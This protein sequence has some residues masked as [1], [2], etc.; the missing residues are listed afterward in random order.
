MLTM[1]KGQF[2]PVLIKNMEF[3]VN[4]VL[5]QQQRFLGHFLAV[6]VDQLNTVVVVR[7]MASRNHDTTV[8][9]VHTGNVSYRRRGSNVQQIGICARSSQTS[10]QTIL[11]HIGAAAGILTDDNASRIGVTIAL[12]QRIIIPAQETTYFVGMVCC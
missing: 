11:E 8:K 4:V 3:A 5:H 6:A 2:R 1:S 12:T 9:V 7:I 10:D